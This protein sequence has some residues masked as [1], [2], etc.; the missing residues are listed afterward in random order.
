MYDG[1]YTY[2]DTA[3]LVGFDHNISGIA[4]KPLESKSGYLLFEVPNEV[5]TSDKS[6]TLKINFKSEFEEGSSIEFPL[7]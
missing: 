4:V 7:R 2:P 3:A 5:A 6:L 1:S